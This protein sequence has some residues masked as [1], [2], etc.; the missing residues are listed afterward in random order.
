M[1]LCISNWCSY[2]GT[3]I[4]IPSANDKANFAFNLHRVALFI[5]HE[6]SR[7][8]VLQNRVKEARF[9]PLKTNQSK[10][11]VDERPSEIVAAAGMCNGENNE[12]KAVWHELLSPLTDADR[13]LWNPVFPTDQRNR[14]N[15]ELY[16]E[17]FIDSGIQKDCF[18]I[19]CY[20]SC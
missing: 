6:S 14:C 1:N 9:V 11:E 18:Y 17:I 5:I 3:C 2:N 16:P 4:F 7:W 20:I 10:K 8:L 12:D 15:R 13:Q 19:D